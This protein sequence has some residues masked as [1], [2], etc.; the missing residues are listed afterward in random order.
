MDIDIE[1]DKYCCAKLTGYDPD[2]NTIS[3][4]YEFIHA[5]NT[6]TDKDF[7]II[8]SDVLTH[9]FLHGLLCT[10]FNM[11]VSKLFDSIEHLIGDYSLKKEFFASLTGVT[12]WHDTI[13][14]SGIQ[15]F[16]NIYH[17]DNNRINQA[18]ILTGGK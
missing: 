6:L 10:E 1:I 18:Y 13:L 14:N 2:T 5:K 11:T 17:I 8:L 16:F 3:L 9:E 12:T 4:G 7:N 15:E